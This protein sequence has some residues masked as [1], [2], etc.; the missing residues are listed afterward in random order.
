MPLYREDIAG[1]CC[2]GCKK[3]F[4]FTFFLNI[5]LSLFVELDPYYFDL[6]SN[7]ILFI[8]ISYSHCFLNVSNYFFKIST[9][10]LPDR[11]KS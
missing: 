1:I 11:S 2:P 10:V 6:I 8:M 9:G 4:Y 5:I 3:V 7:L